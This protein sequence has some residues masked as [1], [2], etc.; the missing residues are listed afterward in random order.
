MA[1][2][3]PDS[4]QK[5]IEVPASTAW[6]IVLALGLTLVFAGLLTGASIS[7]LGAVI[8]VVGGAGWFRN[9]LPSEAHEAVPV[10]PEAP[11]VTTLRTEVARIEI[12]RVPYHAYLPLETYPVSAGIKGGL[13]G[14]VAMAFLAMLYGIFSGNGIWYPVNL[15]AAG[16]YP[17]TMSENTAQ[18]ATFSLGVFSIAASIH[19]I[20]SVFV[21]LLYGAMLPMLPRRP[22]LLGGFIAPIL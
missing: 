1:I 11:A 4:T 6:P 22:V 3:S 19:L 2:E 17:A 21:G 7:I 16:F 12:S 14:S 18:I 20:T 10:L 15:L 9:V 13:A 5:T 8:A